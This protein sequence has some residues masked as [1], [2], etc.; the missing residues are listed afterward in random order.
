VTNCL[1]TITTSD[2][3]SAR[4]RAQSL[5]VHTGIVLLVGTPNVYPEHAQSLMFIIVPGADVSPHL[6]C[7]VHQ[8]SARPNLA[9]GGVA[10]T[11]L[12]HDHRHRRCPPALR[13]T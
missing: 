1:L 9:C 3:A 4:K 11:D 12:S 7:S 2:Y 10:S 8:A 6:W 13:L 5:N